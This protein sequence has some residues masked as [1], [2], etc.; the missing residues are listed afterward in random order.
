MG[1]V[2]GLKAVGL[3]PLFPVMPG[4]TPAQ[5]CTFELVIADCGMEISEVLQITG[6]KPKTWHRN[7]LLLQKTL[8][9]A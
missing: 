8:E 5:L 3:R 4:P 6:K 9:A 2:V 7:L 1:Q